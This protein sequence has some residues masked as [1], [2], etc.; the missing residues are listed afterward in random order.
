MVRSKH[1]SVGVV[2]KQTAFFSLLLF[3]NCR[4]DHSTYT[5]CIENVASGQVSTAFYLHVFLVLCYRLLKQKLF[6][7]V[8]VTA[9][10][11][12]AAAA[13]QLVSLHR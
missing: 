3:F 13:L 7:E 5:T 2:F 6:Q 1:R 10:S 8:N 11:H 9:G 12:V 4:D